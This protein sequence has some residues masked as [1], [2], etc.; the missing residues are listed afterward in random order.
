MKHLLRLSRKASKLNPT[1]NLLS[2][3]KASVNQNMAEALKI[4]APAKSNFIIEFL[5]NRDP[6]TKSF[7]EAINFA[8][9]WLLG[10]S[11]V[12]FAAGYVL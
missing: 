10:A 5:L 12:Q 4:A 6:D 9:Q 2:R 11:N 7:R 1:I 3:Y 8:I